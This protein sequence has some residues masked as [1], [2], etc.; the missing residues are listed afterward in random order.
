[1]PARRSIP[2]THDGT[3]IDRGLVGAGAGKT[4]PSTYDAGFRA[5]L[6]RQFGAARRQHAINFTLVAGPPNV[7]DIERGRRARAIIRRLSRAG[8]GWPSTSTAFTML[9]NQVCAPI[10]L[11]A[12]TRHLDTYFANLTLTD[13]TIPRLG[14]RPR[15]GRST[16][17]R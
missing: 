16:A 15:A 11:P 7:H 2:A 3:F 4:A 5:I 17:S 13:K 8:A 12:N 10:E 14:H 9:G 6:P 1:V